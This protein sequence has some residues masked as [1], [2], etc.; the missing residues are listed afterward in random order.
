MNRRN[1]LKSLYLVVTYLLVLLSAAAMA[2][3]P[4]QAQPQAHPKNG[5]L[6]VPFDFYISGNKLP[7]GAYQLDMIAP[8]YVMLRSSDGK[9]QQDLYFF[10]SAVPGA[11]TQSKVIFAQREGKYYFS[12]VWGWFGKSQLTSFTPK[13]SDLLKEVPLTPTEKTV[14]KPAPGL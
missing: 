5:T 9:V 1:G 13:P 14:A 10:Q 7:A 11:K 4:A 3:G 6:D 8:T 12:Q 2:Q